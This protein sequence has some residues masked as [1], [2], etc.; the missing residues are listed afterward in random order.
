[1]AGYTYFDTSYVC[2]NGKSEGAARKALVE[3][4]P[5]ESFTVAAKF[6]TFR[7]NRIVELISLLTFAG[8]DKTVVK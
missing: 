1:M 4:Y 8:V 6:P 2:H 7:S 5:R 3:R